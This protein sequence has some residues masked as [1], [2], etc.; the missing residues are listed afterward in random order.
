MSLSVE[1]PAPDFTLP[2]TQ[3]GEVTLSS[4]LGNQNVVLVFY[5]RGFPSDADTLKSITG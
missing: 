1:D 3:D 5:K 2:A 4:F